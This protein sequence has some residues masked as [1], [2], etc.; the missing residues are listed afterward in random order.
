MYLST[1]TKI[2]F[3]PNILVTLYAEIKFIAGIS[4]I[5]PFLTLIAFK[6]KKIAELEAQAKEN[7]E[8]KAA[9]EESQ[10]AEEAPAAEKEQSAEQETATQQYTSSKQKTI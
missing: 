4:T 9:E 2:T 7:E 5:S 1:S 6:A 8:A 3:A 10:V